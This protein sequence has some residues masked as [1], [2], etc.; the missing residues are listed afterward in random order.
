MHAW[1]ALD[2]TCPA[3][4]AI[5]CHAMHAWLALDSTCPAICANLFRANLFRSQ[6]QVKMRWSSSKLQP[7]LHFGICWA[8]SPPLRFACDSAGA[9]MWW[10]HESARDGFDV[11]SKHH[12]HHLHVST[13]HTDNGGEFL[14]ADLDAFCEESA[15]R[16]SFSVPCCPPQNAS[17][18]RMW[19]RVTHDCP[20]IVSS[21]SW[22]IRAN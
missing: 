10:V 8:I 17:A 2:S 19:G 4:F 3:A 21:I 20:Q 5:C 9:C 11:F 16:R 6:W 15:T 18:E 1:L 13:L 7:T 12:K 22:T 14:K